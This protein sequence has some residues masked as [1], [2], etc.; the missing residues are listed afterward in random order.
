MLPIREKEEEAVRACFCK[1][2]S[3]QTCAPCVMK[4]AEM[5]LDCI[6]IDSKRHKHCFAPHR[7]P[8]TVTPGS[9]APK[10]RTCAHGTATGRGG[11]DRRRRQPIAHH[12][13]IRPPMPRKRSDIAHVG[14]SSTLNPPFY[15]CAPTPHVCQKWLLLHRKEGKKQRMVGW[16]VC[17][18]GHWVNV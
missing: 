5:R 15:A 9:A 11:G 3:V 16:L 8:G 2:G 17:S 13:T 12:P 1:R 4:S 18:C 10:R 7:A 14:V 6:P